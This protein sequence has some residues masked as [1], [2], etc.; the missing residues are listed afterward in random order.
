MSQRQPQR[1]ARSAFA[2]LPDS[3]IDDV[4]AVREHASV[5][6]F[7]ERRRMHCGARSKRDRDCRQT[8]P[9]KRDAGGK[10]ERGDRQC[11][12]HLPVLGKQHAANLGN[13][14]DRE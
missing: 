1:D 4:L 12:V 2:H 3:C 5:V 13:H 14:H 11:P 8:R 7:A 10:T 6:R 9:A